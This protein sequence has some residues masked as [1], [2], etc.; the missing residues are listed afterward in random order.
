MMQQD[1]ILPDIITYNSLLKAA[2]AAGLLEE[3]QRLYAE[4]LRLGLQPT[5]FTYVGLLKA[6]ANARS[7]D[8]AWLLQVG[9]R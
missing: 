1:V 2:A 7:G 6:A 9:R 5:T 4:L 3:A 8:T